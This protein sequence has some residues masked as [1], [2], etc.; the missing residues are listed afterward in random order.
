MLVARRGNES[1]SRSA[2]RTADRRSL[3]R[4][5]SSATLRDPGCPAILAGFPRRPVGD[6]DARKPT[7]LDRRNSPSAD[8]R[9][10]PRCLLAM[11]PLLPSLWTTFEK[12]TSP[13]DRPLVWPSRH[14]FRTEEPN[15]G[16]ERGSGS[17]LVVGKDSHPYGRNPLMHDLGPAEPF[18][19]RPMPDRRPGERR[20]IR[21]LPLV[22]P[23]QG[24]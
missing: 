16:D 6:I 10:G 24:D 7:A 18:G 4:L 9:D 15:A 13:C 2:H 21:R 3:R 19:P 11:P 22:R 1:A 8:N 12:G 17:D 20:L 23:G 14:G 5:G